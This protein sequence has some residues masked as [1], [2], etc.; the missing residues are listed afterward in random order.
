MLLLV[1][2]CN[3]MLLHVTSCYFMYLLTDS[4]YFTHFQYWFSYFQSVKTSFNFMLLHIT[5]C[6]FI[7]IYYLFSVSSF[8]IHLTFS[9]I[10]LISF[11]SSSVFT[12]IQINVVHRAYNLDPCIQEIFGYGTY[13][14][15][16]WHCVHEKST[17][18][19]L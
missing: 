3:V 7:Y 13:L 17:P 5:S 11:H 9:I 14:R 1:T 18:S 6:Y 4:S 19:I 12:S 10:H 15:N 16:L 8:K 2:L